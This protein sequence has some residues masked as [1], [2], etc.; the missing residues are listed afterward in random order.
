MDD[1]PERPHICCLCNLTPIIADDIKKGDAVNKPPENWEEIKERL[2]HKNSFINMDELTEEQKKT[3]RERRRKAYRRQKEKK[4]AEKKAFEQKLDT[5]HNNPIEYGKVYRERYGLTVSNNKQERHIADSEMLKENASYF[6]NDLKT[7][8][9]VINK[10]AGT[11]YCY[12]EGNRLLEIITDSRL[13]GFCKSFIDGETYTTNL[14]KIHYSKTG[15][16]IVPTL[17]SIEKE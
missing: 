13:N 4:E 15:V 2:R 6:K 10:K 14:A 1:A 7:L 9:K 8:Q 3:L 12:F 17:R 11:G 5:L 16:H